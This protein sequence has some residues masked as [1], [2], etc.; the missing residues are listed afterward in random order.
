MNLAMRSIAQLMLAALVLTS[1]S[2][3]S[4]PEGSASTFVVASTTSVQDSGLLD[5]LVPAFERDF[6]NLRAKVV[7]VGSGEAM[8]LGRR[9]D[10]DVLLVHSPKQ[11]EKFMSDGLGEFRKRVMKNNFVIAGPASDPAAIAGAPDASVAFARI[12]GAR[13]IFLSRGDESGTHQRE[14]ELWEKSGIGHSGDWYFESGQGMAETLA[15]AE[16]HSAYV[17][18]DTATFKVRADRTSLKV[19]FEGD[20]L[21]VNPYSVIS[22]KSARNREAALAF[23]HWITGPKGQQAF[24]TFGVEQYGSR[25]FEPDAAPE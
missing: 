22:V 18:T 17:L 5:A 14:L 1:C 15:I 10:A 19:L 23:A 2:S 6:P 20:P 9:G 11:E 8:D 13:N 4:S 7:A 25:L 12:A 16:Q 24:V 21:L 3:N